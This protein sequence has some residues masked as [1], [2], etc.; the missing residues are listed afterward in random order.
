MNFYWP[1]LFIFIAAGIL[2]A[3]TGCG[4]STKVQRMD[5]DEVKDI[6]GKWNDA[7]S[8]MVADEMIQ[9]CLSRPWLGKAKE[10]KGAEPTV[11]VGAVRNQSHE[12][13]NTDTFVENLQRALINSGDVEFV[14]SKG[15]RGE[16]RDERL[17]QD[18]NASEETRKEHGQ[19]SGADFMLSGAINTIQDSEGGKT[20]MFYQV[21]LKLLNMKSNKISWNGEKKIKKFIKQ[22]KVSW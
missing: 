12:H 21:N 8:K 13:I 16:V 18:A 15:E 14:A 22:A 3:A 17:D 4:A 7:D 2:P 20:V 19:E 9:D 1:F 6:S 10:A 11:I 5:V